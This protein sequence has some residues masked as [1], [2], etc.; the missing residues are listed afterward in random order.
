[1]HSI[2]NRGHVVRFRCVSSIWAVII[3]YHKSDKQAKRYMHSGTS[4]SII[5]L[6]SICTIYSIKILLTSRHFS[7][8]LVFI[9]ISLYMRQSNKRVKFCIRYIMNALTA[10]HALFI[11]LT[12]SRLFCMYASVNVNEQNACYLQFTTEFTHLSPQSCISR[13]WFFFPIRLYAC[14][15][16]RKH[17]K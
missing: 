1:M 2:C 11:S 12:L 13:E 10:L 3:N 9:R 14:V 6:A 8:T 15:S 7:Y 4:T 16:Q 17:A 5:S